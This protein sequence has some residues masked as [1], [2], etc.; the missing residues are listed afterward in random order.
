M[1]KRLVQIV[2]PLVC[3]IA[4]GASPRG[5]QEVRTGP[6]PEIR[7]LV[8][9]FLKALDGD[10]AGWEAMAKEHFS[11]DHLKKTSAADRKQMFEK[12]KADFG[13]VTF[14]RATREGPDAPLDLH[15]TGSTGATGR[16]SLELDAGSPP[17]ISNVKVAVGDQTETG[18]AGVPP[19]PI[20]ARMTPAELAQAIDGY[21]S[22][23]TAADTFSGVALVARRETPVFHQ[24]YGFADRA[25]RIPNTIRTRF[26]IGSI[27][28]AFTKVAIAEL[29]QQ[30]RLSYADTLEKFF[31]DYPQPVSRAATVQQL[32]SHTAGLSDFFGPDFTAAPKDGFRSNAD[33]FR[34]VSARPPLFAPGARN[35]Y[36]NGCYIALGAIVEKVSGMPYEQYVAEHIF[37]RADMT[38]TGYPQIDAI[39]PDIA[40]GYTRRTADGQ[41]RSS[42]Y[43][44]GA[45]GSAAGG[46]YST[47][48]DLFAYVKA[49]GQGRFQGAEKGMAIGGGA[50]G[51]NAVIESNGEWTV[52][53][54]TNLDPPTGER[55]GGAIMKA[56]ESASRP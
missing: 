30:G 18:A 1:S 45:A 14:Q 5:A 28:K 24:A 12:I 38:S 49:V 46:G 51:T 34:F 23:L 13:K 37:K 50:P 10:A 53:V 15:V 26:N 2:L 56:L 43:L 55:I 19:P 4:L 48:M 7:A 52:I 8:D 39:E 33:Y 20:R 6:P 29:V 41:L 16:I 21:L 42:V 40:I 47:A 36:C 35:Q 44:H 31:P 11:A 25:N 27:N 32:V 17:R 9:A 22:T 3:A 54:L